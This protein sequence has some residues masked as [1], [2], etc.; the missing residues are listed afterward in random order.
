MTLGEKIYRLRTENGMSQE[1]FGETL[2]VSRQS[3]SKWETDQSVPELD[4]IVAISEMFAVTTDYLLKESAVKQEERKDVFDTGASESHFSEEEKGHGVYGRN[5]R[6]IVQR[7]SFHYEYKS[8][9]TFLG[10]P[11][12]H[13][14]IGLRPVRAKGVIAIGNA[15]QGIIAIGIAGIGIITFAPVGIGLLLAI[16]VCA[17]GGV[18]LG[19]LAVGVLAGGAISVGIFTMGALAVGQFS[20]GALAVGQQVAIGDAA[21]GNIALGFSEAVG[22][23]Y[24]EVQAADGSFDYQAMINAI[25]ANVPGYF[26]IFAKWMKGIVR[27]MAKA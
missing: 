12:I 14:N 18:A 7:S 25:D 22:S 5:S 16:G 8:K 1:V 13:V 6:V 21:H 19:S 26:S 17:L 20:F 24:E 4:K 11:L 27:M 3:V 10:L 9:K 15:A 2:G 23:I